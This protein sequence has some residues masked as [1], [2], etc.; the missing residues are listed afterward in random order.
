MG[1]RLD[2]LKSIVGTTEQG[3]ITW[4]FAVLQTGYGQ[5]EMGGKKMSAS[6]AICILAHGEPPLGMNQSAH[7]CGNRIC[8]NPNHLRWASVSQNL[9]DRREHGTLTDVAGEANGR[10]K[11]TAE[12]AREIRRRALAGTETHYEIAADYGVTFSTVSDIK[13]GKSW[14]EAVV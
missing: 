11:L 2:F 13:R 12:E 10:A 9:N 14:P 7:R 1:K 5:M 6:R 8:V 3:C 4:P